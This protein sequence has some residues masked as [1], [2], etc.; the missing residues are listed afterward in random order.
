MAKIPEIKMRI[1]TRQRLN[2]TIRDLC[3]N[4]LLHLITHSPQLMDT[5]LHEYYEDI[6]GFENFTGYITINVTKDSVAMENV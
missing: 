2:L 3:N 1:E 4:Q 6:G 5:T